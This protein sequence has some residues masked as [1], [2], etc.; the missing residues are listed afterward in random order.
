MLPELSGISKRRRK[1]GINQAELARRANVSQSLIAKIERGAIDPSYTKTKEIFDVLGEI[2]KKQTIKA[3]D[4]L[5]QDLIS[6]SRSDKV[7]EAVSIMR[8]HNISQLPVFDRNTQVGSFSENTLADALASGRPLENI[9]GMK[10][11][12][13]MEEPFPILPETTPL[14]SITNLLAHNKAILIT[15][16]GKISGIIAKADLLK[17]IG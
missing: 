17:A 13:I 16:K 6:V 11:G 4:I 12:D 14:S 5:T 10:V 9:S 2:E 1:A 3:K 7:G 8:K 15:H